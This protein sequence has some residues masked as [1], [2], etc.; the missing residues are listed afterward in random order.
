MPRPCKN[1]RINEQ[2]NV[3]YFKPAGIPMR[4]LEE[5][6]LGIDEIEAIR[7]ADMEQLYQA[8]AAKKMGISRQT[9]G[10]IIKSA[11]QKIAN[12]LIKGNAIR[13]ESGAPVFYSDNK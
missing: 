11:H 8:D 10:N 9:F 3:T 1:R 5:V 7:L 2:F 13:V 4:V 12:A 6:S